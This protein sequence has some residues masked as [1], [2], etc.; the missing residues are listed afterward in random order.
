MQQQSAISS[1]RSCI[2]PD[3]S[4]DATYVRKLWLLLAVLTMLMLIMAAS[5]TGEARYN[6]LGHRMICM[7]NSE[8]V[9]FSNAGQRGCKQV[10]LECNH[11]NCDTS[12]PMRG[13]LKAALQKG[14]SDDLI[15]QS[16]VR[17]YGTNV[18][19][20]SNTAANKLIWTLA[21]AVLISMAV[22]FV[23][24]WKSSPATVA[25]PAESYDVGIDSLRERV[26]QETEKDDWH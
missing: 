14:D 8:P 10:L 13:E 24:K 20:Q 18:V 19:E 11:L 21:F 1:R 12:G 9:A 22:A 15:L 3:A 5:D 23:R 4:R 2:T 25:T 26:R 17:K 7:C 16:F 6:K